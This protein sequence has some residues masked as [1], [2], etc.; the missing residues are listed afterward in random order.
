VVPYGGPSPDPNDCMGPGR[1]VQTYH[2]Y[3]QP[4]MRPVGGSWTGDP[5][6]P[7][8]DTSLPVLVDDVQCN[9]PHHIRPEEAEGLQ[10]IRLGAQLLLVCC[11]STGFAGLVLDG[12]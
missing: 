8:A 1:T 2:A 11:R 3:G 9:A 5:L 6:H 10:G 4:Y 12:M 7:V